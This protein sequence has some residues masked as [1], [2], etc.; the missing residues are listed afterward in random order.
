[1]AREGARPRSPTGA[2]PLESGVGTTDASIID[3][4][5]ADLKVR[6]SPTNGQF[7]ESLAGFAVPVAELAP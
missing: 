3:A 1:M 6:R 7:P 4:Q 5:Q 2:R